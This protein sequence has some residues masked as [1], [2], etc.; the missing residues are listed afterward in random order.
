VPELARRGEDFRETVEPVGHL[1]LIRQTIR[2][3]C[4]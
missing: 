2:K 3:E 1:L 4:V